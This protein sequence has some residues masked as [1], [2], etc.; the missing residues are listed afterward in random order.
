VHADI[1]TP[2]ELQSA[3]VS[4]PAAKAFAK[5][6]LAR[7]PQLS[8]RGLLDVHPKVSACTIAKLPEATLYIRYF[9]KLVTSS[10]SDCSPTVTTRPDGTCT[11]KINN[12][13]QGVPR[14]RKSKKASAHSELE[15]LSGTG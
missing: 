8:F 14:M 7:L 11:H 2:A 10:P 4:S 3:V 15:A 9:S 12:T 5:Y 1:I 13:F 6:G